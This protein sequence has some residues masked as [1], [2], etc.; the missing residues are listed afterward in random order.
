MSMLPISYRCRV[1]ALVFLGATGLAGCGG[2]KDSADDDVTT[3]AT[4]TTA[5][6]MSTDAEAVLAAYEAQWADFVRASDP[7]DPDA[8]YLADHMTGK[9]LASSHNEL[10]KFEAEGIGL[11]GAV[12][13]DASVVEIADGSAVIEDCN[14]DNT[15]TYLIATGE[16]VDTSSGEPRGLI[17]N[18][19][20][21]DDQWK[22]TSFE[23]NETV[24]EE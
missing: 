16:V 4:A 1:A 10:Q 9:V 23:R 3:E 8:A 5:P 11:R 20:L 19:L 21:E 24:C 22:I 13:T 17:A 18:M 2:A 14:R 6:E 15:K 7:P 12:Q